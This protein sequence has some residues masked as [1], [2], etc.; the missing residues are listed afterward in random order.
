MRGV[1]AARTVSCGHC[2]EWGHNARRCPDG[3][4][5]ARAHAGIREVLDEVCGFARSY[6]PESA[7]ELRAEVL[8]LLSVER[9]AMRKGQKR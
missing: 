8:R 6:S 2:G 4:D 5:V 7:E 3:E 1:R 9:R